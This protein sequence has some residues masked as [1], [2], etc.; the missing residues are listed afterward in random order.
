MEGEVTGSGGGGVT[1]RGTKQLGGGASVSR[2]FTTY[3]G[4]ARRYR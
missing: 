3:T 4:H 2:V 1:G